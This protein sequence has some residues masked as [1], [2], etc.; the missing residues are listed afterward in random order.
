[1]DT[2]AIIADYY[3]SLTTI[4]DEEWNWFVARLLEKRIEKYQH[5]VK[6]GQ[7]AHEYAFI[8]QGFMYSY[9]MKEDKEIVRDFFS[10]NSHAS[11]HTS[12]ITRTPSLYSIQALEPTTILTL[13]YH[14]N[15]ELFCRHSCW[16]EIGRLTAEE[17]YKQK[18]ERERSFLLDTPE[19]RYMKILKNMPEVL[20][21]APQYHI[22]S[23]LGIS[24]E[25]LSRIRRKIATNNGPSSGVLS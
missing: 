21:R 20:Q 6:E 18:E 19:T 8:V 17:R 13:S 25:T 16:Q 5:W 1:M 23:Y 15:Q 24:P 7:I 4:P 3:H 2:L 14:D 10:E 22:A 11:A 12:L 9:Y